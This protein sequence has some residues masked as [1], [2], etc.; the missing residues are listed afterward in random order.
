MNNM[1]IFVFPSKVIDFMDLEYC[2]SKFGKVNIDLVGSNRKSTY[3][4][5]EVKK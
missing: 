3:I 1:E 4:T 5:A 2:D